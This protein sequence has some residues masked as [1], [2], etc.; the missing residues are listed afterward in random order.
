MVSKNSVTGDSIQTKNISEAY[1][2]NYDAI[3]GVKPT[4]KLDDEK[5][6]QDEHD[7]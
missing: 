3:F 2:E 5:V 6:I 1:R 7:K 4:E